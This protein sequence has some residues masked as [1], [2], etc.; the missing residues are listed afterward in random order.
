MTLDEPASSS[1]RLILLSLTLISGWK[2]AGLL[3]MVDFCTVFVLEGA[4][5]PPP[6]GWSLRVNLGLYKIQPPNTKATQ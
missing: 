3:P 5:V 4:G 6:L 2:G 1:C